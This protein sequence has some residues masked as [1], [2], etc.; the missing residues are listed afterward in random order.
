MTLWF[1]L[2]KLLVAAATIAFASWL[3]DKKPEL[4]GFIIALPIVSLLALAFSYIE[5]A[6]PNAS[7][8]FAKSIMIGIP[9]S[10]LF[11]IPFFFADKFNNH[12]WL[13]YL[14]GILLLLIG[15][16]IHRAILSLIH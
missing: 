8:V 15:F 12:F 16:F 1:T 4:A 13:T 9:V 6:N 10:Y 11:F 5:H 14:T 7:I 2:T 3:S